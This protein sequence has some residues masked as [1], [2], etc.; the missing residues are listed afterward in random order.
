MTADRRQ[1]LIARWIVPVVPEG[2]VLEG[3][4]LVLDGE[5]IVEI[6][7]AAALD[8]R[9]PGIARVELPEHVLIPGLV[10][11]HTHSAMALL[12]GLADDLPLMRW[13]HENIWPAEKIIM[14]P[15]YVAAGSLLAMAEM[16]R[17]GTTCFNDNYFFPDVTAAEALDAG[18][19]AVVGMPV[20]G[21]PTPWAENDDEYFRRG[22]E[23]HQQFH[24]EKLIDVCFVPH[25]PYS[26]GD[27]AFR[28]IV[29]LAEELDTLIHLHLLESADEITSSREQYGLH[30]L[31]RLDALGVLGPRLLAVHMTQLG[32]A[33][34][35]R[36]ARAGVHVV[37]CPDSNMKL[38]SGICPVADLNAAGV[39]VCLGT[40]GAASNNDLSL[41]AEMRQSALLAKLASGNPEAIPAKRA[42]S[43]ATIHGAR[44]LGLD[45]RIGSIEPGKQAD[46]A[47]IRLDCIETQ[48][49]YDVISQIVYAVPDSQV[50]D[51][52]VAGRR[53][54]ADRALTTL[55]EARI[56]ES[57]TE[58]RE[59]IR[60]ALAQHANT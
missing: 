37:H 55:D 15:D 41:I 53:L 50:T 6:L 18:M 60:H 3:Q 45:D 56:L 36:L 16:L 20:I 35:A 23:V 22:L 9:Y 31:D 42:L 58:W 8:A 38:A 27:E 59:R 17:S 30:P 33:D 29:R 43:M 26:V 21:F 34:P 1:A 49:V 14:G 7:P 10:N 40:D 2:E 57:C 4:A 5:T 19:R 11:M 54:L 25:A 24:G 13:L 28:R 46:L 47:A 39:N 52:W 51:V 12:R 44:A 32:P 48:P